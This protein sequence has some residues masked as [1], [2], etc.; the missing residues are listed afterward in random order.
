MAVSVVPR[1][2]STPASSTISLEQVGDVSSDGAHRPGQVGTAHRGRRHLGDDVA[3]RRLHPQVAEREPALLEPLVEPDRVERL[4]RVALQRD[5]V[6]DAAELGALVD[7][8]HLDAALAQTEGE[9]AAG[10][11][12]ADDDDLLDS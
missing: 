1:R 7:E 4:E 9:H 6:A 12:A 3:V 11:A 5:A 10:D 8:D 2:T